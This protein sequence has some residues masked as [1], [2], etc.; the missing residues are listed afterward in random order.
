MR[1]ILAE[2]MVD[3]FA[4]REAGISVSVGFAELDRVEPTSQ[5][6]F[7]DADRGL[8]RA[9]ANGRARAG[10]I[11][12][13]GTGTQAHVGRTQDLADPVF[14][15]ADWD[16]LE[17]SLRESNRGALEAS[18]IIDSLQSTESVGFGY[19][20]RAFRLLRINAMLAAVHGG[21]VEDQIGRTVAEVV[22]ALWPTLEPLYRPRHRQR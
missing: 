16:R 22:P 17:E 6:L 1:A 5:R 14:A 2:R 4:E 9:K 19:V 21:R 15:Q 12:D 8:Y 3:R 18:S 7:R 20:D 11:G 10:T 13:P